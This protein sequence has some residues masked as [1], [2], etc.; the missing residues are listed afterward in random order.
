MKGEGGRGG[1]VDFEL[2][3]KTYVRYN[4]G[5]AKS[6]FTV[7]RARFQFVL[8][9]AYDQ[10]TRCTCSYKYRCFVFRGILRPQSTELVSLREASI[11]T[12]VM[13]DVY[14]IRYKNPKHA[15]TPRS[16]Q[17]GRFE[18]LQ[19]RRCVVVVVVVVVGRKH[20]QEEAKSHTTTYSR[21][22]TEY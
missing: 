13:L 5:F 22:P 10:T 18:E 11:R 12:M 6:I 3:D 14:Y 16:P 17:Q 7:S 1:G 15:R 2:Q 8:G 9:M 21:L 20:Q 4:N 19:L